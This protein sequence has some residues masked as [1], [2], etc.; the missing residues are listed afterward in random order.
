MWT[1]VELLTNEDTNN[2]RFGHVSKEENGSGLYQV[3]T[4]VK[5]STADAV[6]TCPLHVYLHAAVAA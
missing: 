4:L 2:Y 3:D 1:D 5:I 6:I